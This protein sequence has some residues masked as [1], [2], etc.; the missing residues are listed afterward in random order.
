MDYFLFLFC[1]LLEGAEFL[2]A[3]E[4]D[5][6]FNIVAIIQRLHEEHGNVNIFGQFLSK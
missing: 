4:T 5:N 6:L 3:L 1:T 2:S